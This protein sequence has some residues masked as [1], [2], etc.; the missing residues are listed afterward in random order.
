MPR[1]PKIEGAVLPQKP[2]PLGTEVDISKDDT[3]KFTVTMTKNIQF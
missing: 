2:L 1:M 3:V